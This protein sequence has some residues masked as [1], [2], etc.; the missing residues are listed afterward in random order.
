MTYEALIATLERYLNRSDQTADA[1]TYITLTEAR[2]NRELRVR[3]MLARATASVTDGFADLPTD[4]LSLRTVL[5]DGAALPEVSLDAI[6]RFPTA[7]P[8]RAYC[9]VGT[10][11]QFAPAPTASTVEMAYYRRLT[12]ITEDASNFIL[13]NH[14]DLY[15]YGA[16]AEV[17]NVLRD[18][19]LLTIAESRFQAAKTALEKASATTWGDRLT[20]IP[21]TVI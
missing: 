1:A 16:L 14:P 9:L 12:P 7:G 8:V 10:E 13:A 21:S 5:L 3:E 18:T 4:F 11:I 19:E 6:Q 17:A 20:P 15:L 2:L